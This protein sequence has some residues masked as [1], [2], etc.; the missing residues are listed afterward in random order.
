MAYSVKALTIGK[1]AVGIFCA[2]SVFFN[3]KFGL[4][5]SLVFAAAYGSADIIKMQ[6]L[7]WATNCWRGKNAPAVFGCLIAF[8]ICTGFSLASAFGFYSMQKDQS[9][10]SANATKAAYKKA[11]VQKKK[12]EATLTSYGTIRAI[13]AIKGDIAASRA[14]KRWASTKGCIPQETTAQLSRK[15]CKKYAG[16]VGELETAKEAQ[17]IKD[18]IEQIENRMNG[19]D[20]KV[21][22][23]SSDAQIE[24]MARISG[25]DT[26]T[27]ISIL[28]IGFML[29]VEVISGLG[30]WLVTSAKNHEAEQLK[31]QLAKNQ[32]VIQV[33]KTKKRKALQQAQITSEYARDLDGLERYFKG[34]IEKSAN[35]Y[36]RATELLDDY[37][38]WCQNNPVIEP[39]NRT[40][41]GKKVKERGILH[42]RLRTSEDPAKPTVYT[43]IV[44]KRHSGNV[45][46]LRS[47]IN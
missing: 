5:Q 42:R 40:T 20:L 34:R 15:F 29:L 16:F 28:A 38:E 10:G 21:V 46:P 14:H 45:I 8:V 23:T 39:L 43:G 25:L 26:K 36:V 18:K 13:G 19:M 7:N 11:E 41:F 17:Q 2:L 35:G 12:L 30:P 24:N 4:S 47:V 32:Q 33:E 9:I 44:L 22:H 37:L 31:Q 3:V 1:L 6:L 27:V